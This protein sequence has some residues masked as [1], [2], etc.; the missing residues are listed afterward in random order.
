MRQ[1][2]HPSGWYQDS[3]GQWFNDSVCSEGEDEDKV[4]SVEPSEE[5]ENRKKHHK[6]HT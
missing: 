3:E 4:G 2:F 1:L 6:Y 5:E